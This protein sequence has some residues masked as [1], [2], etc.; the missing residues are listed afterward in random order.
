MREY[1]LTA[2]QRR[3]WEQLVGP[4]FARGV[5]TRVAQA[6]Q[7]AKEGDLASWKTRLTG[8]VRGA[9]KELQAVFAVPKRR[10]VV[11]QELGVGEAELEVWLLRARGLEVEDDPF[12]TLVPGFEEYG[13]V[14]AHTT[15]MLPPVRYSAAIDRGHGAEPHSGHNLA[16][17]DALCEQLRG[18]ST[19]VGHVVWIVGPPGGGRTALLRAGAAALRE[20]GEQVSF[21]GRMT[22]PWTVL[23]CDDVDQLEPSEREKLLAAFGDGHG[24]RVLLLSAGHAVN[25]APMPPSRCVFSIVPVHV[26]W[27]QS[28]CE[29]LVAQVQARWSLSLD[30][31]PLLAWLE[32]EP[33]ALA[34]VPSPASLGVVIRMVADGQPL[35]PDLPTV[36]RRSMD[37]LARRARLAGD[38]S[39]ALIL[40]HVG[41]EALAAAVSRTCREGSDVL[42]PAEVAREFVAAAD[43]SAGSVAGAWGKLGAPGMLAV[44]ERLRR[45]GV[46]AGAGRGLRVV[47]PVLLGAALGEGLVR[48]DIDAR[49]LAAVV[50]RPEWH[51]A[52]LAAAQRLGDIAPLLRA[53]LALP[54]AQLCQAPAAVLPV[55]A[56][57]IRCSEPELVRRAYTLCLAWWLRASPPP[58]QLHMT[59]SLAPVAPMYE[60]ARPHP[61]LQLAAAATHHRRILPAE[62]SRDALVDGLP[63][64][65]REYAALLAMTVPTDE[66][67]RDRLAVAAP[68]CGDRI[69][70]AELWAR[71]PPEES[72]R[73]VANLSSDDAQLWWRCFATP[74]FAAAADGPRRLV[75]LVGGH[76]IESAMMQ[77]QRG[78][79]IWRDAL[80]LV[81]REDGELAL[82]AWNRALRFT[83]QRGGLTNLHALQEIWRLLT[84]TL[85]AA[86]A[87]ASTVIL[88]DTARA[89]YC[90]A[91]AVAWLVGQVIPGPSLATVWRALAG[92]PRAELPWRQFLAREVGASVVLRWALKTLPTEARAQQAS[93]QGQAITEMLARDDVAVL[94]ALSRARSPWQEAALSRLC[95]RT[96]GPARRVRL[97]LA[98][99]ADDMLRPEL[100]RRL[101]AD[102]TSDEAQAWRRLAYRAHSLPESFGLRFIADLAAGDPRWPYTVTALAYMEGLL[103]EA[104]ATCHR[105]WMRTLPRGVFSDP[106]Q[107]LRHPYEVASGVFAELGGCLALAERR[108]LDTGVVARELVDRPN[109]R[110]LLA[111][112]AQTP[113]WLA[114]ARVVDAERWLDMLEETASDEQLLPA[115]VGS[116]I[117]APSLL[118]RI[119]TRPRLVAA[120]AQYLDSPAIQP[121]PDWL[122]GLCEQLALDTFTPAVG[123]LWG[124]HLA[125]A[126]TAGV[127][128][129]VRR[130]SGLDEASRRAWWASVLPRIPDGVARDVALRALFGDALAFER[131]S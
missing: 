77:A 35:A 116:L 48:A 92:A 58:R 126:G 46:L 84:M 39:S 114:L 8:F 4:R 117:G 21:W 12:K 90:F 56:L 33:L 26:P 30:L 86:V 70:S 60:L 80:A 93:A 74:R 27:A 10:K 2:E 54:P 71:L 130:V 106:G 65:L 51:L 31:A 1:E 52:L 38:E 89:D 47:S 34:W 49:L 36:L 78:T 24:G 22:E 9:A 125:I 115:R 7:D 119:L 50:L 67:A 103:G 79:A 11:A 109:V 18:R 55:L 112:G 105:R 76:A 53:L 87:A 43:G 81:F 122:A 121:S 97:K 91:D 19:R 102:A 95:E 29:R 64:P 3:A 40:E 110:S 45:L 108:G 85:R 88:V 57:G 61:Y 69:F 99:R 68:W 20:A 37:H 28:L 118:P 129:F 59:L 42:K 44:V 94:A 15:P 113:I 104:R 73:T 63:A 131:S 123:R 101:A 62:W 83:L 128:R 23:A 127:E 107:L 25:L 32:D 111:G 41:A 16:W 66:E 96:D 17:P 75:G 98:A 120:A 82:P 124:L 100:L 14:P 72:L 6:L 13:P 5:R